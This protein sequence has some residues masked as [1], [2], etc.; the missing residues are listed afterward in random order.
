MTDMAVD[1][2]VR[3]V[4]AHPDFAKTFRHP[5]KFNGTDF[6]E[7]RMSQEEQ[8]AEVAKLASKSLHVFLERYGTML[9]A[10]D[11]RAISGCPA[12]ATAEA[13]FWIERLLR[14]PAS[15]AMRQKQ[16]RRRRWL[17][18]RREM[19]RSDG[20][21]SEEEMKRRDPRLFHQMVGRH[22]DSGMQL[23]APMQGSLSGYL[24]QQLDKEVDGPGPFGRCSHPS[25]A[26]TGASAEQGRSKRSRCAGDVG[27]GAAEGCSSDMQDDDADA[28]PEL[29]PSPDD[30]SDGDSIDSGDGAAPDDVA[31]RR[32][33]FLKAMRDR[34]VNGGE[35]DF[36]YAVLDEDSDLDDV[37]ELGRDAEEKYFDND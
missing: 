18:A 12:A 34:F 28:G 30:M 17:W 10:E 3:R 25:G 24:M 2:V 31:V 26:S 27:G 32:A 23:S 29:P 5:L 13:R 4:V 14:S 21:F 33:H 37:V 19:S 22:L 15:D 16:R 20:F 6:V 7:Q 1:T 8:A 35:P 36:D 9:L 11:V